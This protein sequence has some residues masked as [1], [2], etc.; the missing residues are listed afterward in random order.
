MSH[1]PKNVLVATPGDGG[2]I[3]SPPIMG[4]EPVIP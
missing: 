1:I 2:D 3:L 4:K